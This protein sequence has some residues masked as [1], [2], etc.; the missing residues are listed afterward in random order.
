M[1]EYTKTVFFEIVLVTLC[2]AKLSLFLCYT[3]TIVCWWVDRSVDKLVMV[4]MMIILK[5]GAKIELHSLPLPR[6]WFWACNMH[7]HSVGGLQGGIRNS[8]NSVS[9]SFR[10]QLRYHMIQSTYIIES[11]R[12]HQNPICLQHSET[13]FGIS[14]FELKPHALSIRC[15]SYIDLCLTARQWANPGR[16]TQSHRVDRYL[17]KY[18]L[19]DTISNR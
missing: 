4:I 19:T 3:C 7:P 13:Q 10:F 16:S 8:R 6:W 5:A 9:K 14:N 1:Q 11:K 18:Y 12:H 15:V 2:S 17:F